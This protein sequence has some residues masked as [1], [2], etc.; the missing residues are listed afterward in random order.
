MSASVNQNTIE[1]DFEL[2]LDKD[3]ALLVYTATETDD[4]PSLWKQTFLGSFNERY[5]YKIISDS[6][7][8]SLRLPCFILAFSAGV[9]LTLNVPLLLSILPLLTGSVTGTKQ[10]RISGDPTKLLLR[11]RKPKGSRPY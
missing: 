3:D 2:E 6:Q 1:E 4:I 5:V 7:M 10:R 9:H 8:V 11:K